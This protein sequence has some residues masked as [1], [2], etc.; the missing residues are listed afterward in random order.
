MPQSASAAAVREMA[1]LGAQLAVPLLE[2]GEQAVQPGSSSSCATLP[3]KSWA[4]AW[5]LACLPAS[6]PIYSLP[7]FL[8]HSIPALHCPPS[9]C[10]PLQAS[11]CTTCT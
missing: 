3:P 11:L 2:Y 6:A 1:Q 7:H 8:P 5:R 4:H 9:S 10:C